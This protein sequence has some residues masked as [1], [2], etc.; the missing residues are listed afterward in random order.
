MR[1]SE[2][3]PTALPYSDSEFD[4]IFSIGVLEHVY[5]TGGDEVSSLKEIKRTLKPGGLFMCFHF[6]NRYGWIEPTFNFLRLTKKSHK[7][8]YGL[9]EIKNYINISGLE[10][11]EYGLYNFLPRNNLS[12]LPFSIGS[13]KKFIWLYERIDRF[14]VQMIPALCQNYYFIA[15]K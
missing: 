14:L 13:S 5:E 8:K 3:E 11:I 6:P 12:K 9:N 4:V 15:R 7:R 10:L 1:G 2:V